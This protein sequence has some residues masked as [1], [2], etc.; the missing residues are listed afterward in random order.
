M[1][2]DLGLGHAHGLVSWVLGYQ[3]GVLLD[4]KYYKS[5]LS[6]WMHVCML[7]KLIPSFF[8]TYADYSQFVP[9]LLRSLIQLF[10]DDDETVVTVAWDA[11]NAV[12]KVR[13]IVWN[14][15]MINFVHFKKCVWHSYKSQFF[16][17]YP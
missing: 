12:T 4:Y 10:G 16:T 6:R 7:Q 13:K 14:L 9:Q 15:K 11:L 8:L 17:R 2:E 1:L 3:I 5:E